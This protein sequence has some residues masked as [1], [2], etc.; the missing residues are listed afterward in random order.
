[1]EDAVTDRQDLAKVQ[2]LYSGVD[3][4][5]VEQQAKKKAKTSSW[6]LD[7]QDYIMKKETLFD[8]TW[9]YA[10]LEKPEVQGLAEVG[11]MSY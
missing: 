5:V 9:H 11:A 4:E 3:E 10:E 7:L 8:Y 6:G 2:A 1:M